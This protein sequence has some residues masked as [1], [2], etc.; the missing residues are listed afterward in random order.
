MF[1]SG[2][3]WPWKDT[4]VAG[5]D[6]ANAAPFAAIGQI[7]T[8]NGS[9]TVTRASGTVAD[10]KPGDLVYQGDV[11]ET[12]AEGAVGI[13]FADGTAFNLAESARLSLDEFTR[14]QEAAASSALFR[15][16]RGTFAFVAGKLAKSG[17]FRIETPFAS[18]DGLGQ[19]VGFGA[20][21]LAALTF[22][23]IEESHAG[24]GPDS[25][26]TEDDAIEP[27]HGSFVV[28]PH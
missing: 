5:F 19:G 2:G 23:L 15:L 14:G 10:A 21:T 12:A 3:Y 8:V 20:L 4:I 28:I 9:V 16:V 24:P 17:K 6:E 26:Y 7:Q 18:I 13:A 11:I 1:R 27:E 22:S 25:D